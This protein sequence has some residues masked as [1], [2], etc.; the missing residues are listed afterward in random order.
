MLKILLGRLKLWQKF[1]LL[2]GLG[3]ILVAVPL[4]LFI[5]ESNKG[6][7]AAANEASGI[8]P[9]RKI[10]QALQLAQQHRGLSSMLLNG[11]TAAKD[12]RAAKQSE[13]DKAFA[14]LDITVKQIDNPA[15]TT[16]WNTVQSN[17]PALSLKV[18][19]QSIV[20]KASFAQHTAMIEQLMKMN[21]LYIDH[22][23]LSL[24]PNMASDH[25][26]D[27]ALVRIPKV[28][29]ILGR[30]RARGSGVL[31][32]KTITLDERVQLAGLLE[33]ANDLN[34]GVKSSMEKV[35]GANPD[36]KDKLEGLRQAASSS[37]ETVSQ[38]SLTQLIKADQLTLPSDDYFATLT[39]AIDAQ[40]KLNHTALSELTLILDARASHLRTVL[41]SMLACIFLLIVLTGYAGWIVLKSIT[42]PMDEAVEI[43]KRIAAGDLTSDIHPEG[44]NETAELLTALR[45]MND[46]LTRIVTDVR[47]ATDTISTASGE[48]ASGNMD[49]SSRT[50]HQASSLEETASSMEELTST[51]KQNADNARQANQ[52]AVSASEVAVKG[53]TVVSE[54]VETMGSI[55]AS[56]KKIVDII[57]V[58]DGIAFQT[59]ILALN[60]AVEAARAGEQGRGF[61]VVATEVRNLA[62]R[63]AA[64]AKEIK[65]LIGDSVDKVDAGARLVDQAG[66]TMHEIV[67]SIRR[68]TD[69]MSEITAASQEQTSGIEQVNVAI[70]QMDDTTQQNAAL[71]EEAAAAAQSMQN[72]AGNLSM[73]VSVFKL[74]SNSGQ[75]SKRIG[76]AG[77]QGK[78]A[79]KSAPALAKP[80]GKPRSAPVA[81]AAP[82]NN[83]PINADKHSVVA[84]K[85]GSSDD[86]E[87]F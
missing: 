47:I 67:E 37:T 6:L 5:A 24:D 65:T 82:A 59:N 85:G 30:L 52:L 87:E 62:Q 14:E 77:R 16:L 25:L 51:V 57:G 20:A 15:A 38:V 10:L 42:G 40:F 33:N 43:A 66:A 83:A 58:I 61:A 41:Y 46:S 55:N 84:K 23:G 56:S 69:I 44:T 64:A 22:F 7:N 81:P 71:V 72:Q 63:S 27:T 34:L 3:A 73:A 80:A 29:E 11:N 79:P 18:S 60:A 35:I 21:E 2:D 50:E 86:W 53:G 76:N 39:E 19:E 9:A 28:T 68:V 12:K 75:L 74:N 54:V 17:W 8:E 32:Q 45:D 70:G 78:P 13:V 48:I 49:L 36:L 1:V 26:I 31:A 4:L